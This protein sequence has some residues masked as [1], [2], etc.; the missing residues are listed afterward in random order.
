VAIFLALYQ[1]RFENAK[2]LS[3]FRKKFS[4]TAKTVNWQKAF[5]GK[6]RIIFEEGF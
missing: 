6:W 3:T 2:T 1:F 5:A 4:T